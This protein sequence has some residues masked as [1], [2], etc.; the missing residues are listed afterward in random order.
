MA[1]VVSVDTSKSPLELKVVL[2][3]SQ[4]ALRSVEADVSVFGFSVKTTGSIA[5]QDAIKV[6][7]SE[8]TWVFKS[9]DA[10]AR[11]AVFTA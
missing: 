7:D 4:E 5:P 2:D 6:A 9:Y 1:H 10:A 3:S 8:R 11:T